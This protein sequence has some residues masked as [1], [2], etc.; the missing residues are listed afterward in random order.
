MS[1]HKI[2]TKFVKNYLHHISISEQ[3]DPDEAG[4]RGYRVGLHIL[5][6]DG[7]VRPIATTY[8]EPENLMDVLPDLVRADR[9]EVFNLLYNFTEYVESVKSSC[10]VWNDFDT[11]TFSIASEWR[12]N[13][14]L[15]EIEIPIDHD[16]FTSEVMTYLPDRMVATILASAGWQYEIWTK[17]VDNEEVDFDDPS[18]NHYDVQIMPIC[19]SMPNGIDVEDLRLHAQTFYHVDFY[20]PFSN[21]EDFLCGDLMDTISTIEEDQILSHKIY[22]N[23]MLNLMDSSQMEREGYRTDTLIQSHRTLEYREWH[24]TTTYEFQPAK[25]WN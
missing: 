25:I 24:F 6:G 11:S 3:V 20:H 13:A 5:C 21:D 14:N 15:N 1:L 10:E 2:N 8:I 23:K 7:I 4:I 19:E 16:I 22:I 18:A 9:H 12:N 17:V